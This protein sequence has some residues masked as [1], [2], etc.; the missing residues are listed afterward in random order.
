MC[1]TIRTCSKTHSAFRDSTE[2][3]PGRVGSNRAA[4]VRERLLQ[5]KPDRFLTGAALNETSKTRTE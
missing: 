5:L 1:T 2:R 3:V 4:T